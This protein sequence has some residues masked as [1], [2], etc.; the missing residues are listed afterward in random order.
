V[1]LALADDTRVNPARH[2]N[3]QPVDDRGVLVDLRSGRC[4]EL[5]AVGFAIWRLLADGRSVADAAGEI[6]HRYAVDAAVSRTDVTDLVRSLLGE[7]LVA[8]AAGARAG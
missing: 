8:I 6:A 5:N 4:W 3:V 7:G 1:S 2:V